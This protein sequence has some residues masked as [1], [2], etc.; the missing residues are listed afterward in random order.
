MKDSATKIQII[1]ESTTQN[2]QKV[3]KRIVHSSSFTFHLNLSSLRYPL[4]SVL[5][6]DARC[7]R[8][9]MSEEEEAEVSVAAFL[10]QLALHALYGSAEEKGDKVF[11]G[12]FRTFLA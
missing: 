4:L 8:G 5:D 9:L 7:G 6:I 10:C 1:P 2:G 12:S 11:V 3:N